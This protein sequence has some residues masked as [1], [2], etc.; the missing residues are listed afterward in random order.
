MI[1][2]GGNYCFLTCLG[3]KMFDMKPS[4]LTKKSKSVSKNIHNDN[5]V[6]ESSVHHAVCYIIFCLDFSP[7]LE[8][9]ENKTFHLLIA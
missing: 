6:T 5:F 3:F 4:S 8:N 2:H 1:Q 7:A 9:N